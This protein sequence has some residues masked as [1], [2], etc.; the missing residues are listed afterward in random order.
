[1]YY[2]KKT[3]QK[4]VRIIKKYIKYSGNAETEV[5]LLLFFCEQIAAMQLPLHESKVLLN[6][7]Q[8]QVEAIQKAHSKLHEDLQYDYAG[9]ITTVA[10]VYAH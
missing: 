7:Y 6:L 1:L 3:I 5:Q 10:S 2:A 4:I 8:R 9:R